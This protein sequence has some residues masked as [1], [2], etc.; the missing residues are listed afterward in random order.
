MTVK[1]C[2]RGLQVVTQFEVTSKKIE[3][4]KND[5]RGINFFDRFENV[6]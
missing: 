5:A 6:A 4:H 1:R 3:L 2:P